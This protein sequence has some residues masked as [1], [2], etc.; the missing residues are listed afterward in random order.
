MMRG[1]MSGWMSVSD[2]GSSPLVL[3]HKTL[4]VYRVNWL[5]AKARMD[6]WQEEVTLVQNETWWMHLWLDYHRNIWEG[7]AKES[8]QDGLKGHACYAW[9]QVWMWVSQS[10]PEL[11]Y[12]HSSLLIYDCCHLHTF[13]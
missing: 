7:R 11:S 4:Q 6:R 2:K 12:Y 5:R 1:E 8:E 9:K 10:I 13:T 3:F